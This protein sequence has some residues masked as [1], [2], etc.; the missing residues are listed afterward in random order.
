MNE[1]RKTSTWVVD[2]DASIRWVIEKTLARAGIR[3]RQFADAQSCLDALSDEHPDVL[4]TDL[5]MPGLDGHALLERLKRHAN[6]PPV[7]VVSAHSDIDSVLRAYENGAVE[8]LAKPFDVE[9]LLALVLRLQSRNA[10]ANTPTATR[11]NARII[12]DSPAMQTVYRT[13]GRL[14]R[15]AVPVLIIGESGTGK[16]L[17]ARTLHDHSPRRD[18]PFVAINTAAIPSDL[19]ESELFGHERGAFTGAH[20]RRAGRFEQADTGTLFLDE[21]GDMPLEMQTRLLRVLSEGEFFRVGGHQ[22]LRADVR[23][24]AATHQDLQKLIDAGRF[25]EDLYHRLDV[26]R[27][28]I[29]PLRERREDIPMLAE[30]FLEEAAVEL[31]VESKRLTEEA[32]RAL[33]ARDWPGNVRELRNFCRRMTALAPG[34]EITREDAKAPATSGQ[35]PT[36]SDQWVEQWF[37]DERDGVAA[38]ATDVLERAL[39]ERAL[40]ESGGHRHRAAKRLG[41]G[42]NTLTRKLKQYGIDEK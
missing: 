29:P 36:T 19:L 31:D 3:C 38:R 30:K 35:A 8:L 13:I 4:I 23:V 27:L 5:R 20:Q 24:I 42:R 34:R 37:A 40:R 2:D 32:R 10:R 16:E 9:E 11:S 26:V 1:H 33:A 17:V 15:A 21:I 25:R 7:I 14:S 28:D 22:S 12:G 18:K 6:P 41:W 39:I